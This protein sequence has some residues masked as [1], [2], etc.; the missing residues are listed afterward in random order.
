MYQHEIRG[1]IPEMWLAFEAP[2]VLRP[3]FWVALT[4]R[5]VQSSDCIA[6]DEMCC[7]LSLLVT[8]A[9]SLVL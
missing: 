6:L 2:T 3:C 7:V 9:T 8:T 4:N 5:H 1:C